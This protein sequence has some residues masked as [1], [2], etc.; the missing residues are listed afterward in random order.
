M[1]DPHRPKDGLR[2]VAETLVIVVVLVLLLKSF[3]AE[4]F[5]IPTGSMATTLWGYQKMVECPECGYRFP[6]NCSDEVERNQSR[7]A[8]CTCPNCR[9]DIDFASLNMEPA[10]KTGDCVLVGKYLYDSGLVAPNRL[11]VVVFKY[12]ERPQSDYVQMNY[13][14][15]LI[16]LPGETIGIHQ[17]KLYVLKPGRGPSYE[18][19][20]SA[21]PPQERWHDVYTH[22]NRASDLLLRRDAAFDIVRKSPEKI[23][24]MRRIVYDNDHQAADLKN[25]LPPRWSGASAWAADGAHAFRHA[26]SLATGV[27]WL[28]YRNI[29]RHGQAPELITDFL[30]YNTRKHGRGDHPDLPRNWV[31]DLL[32]E[33]DVTIDQ[34]QGAL[35]LELSK[36]N[37][38]FRASWD[39]AS[40]GGTCRLTRVAGSK[41]TQLASKRTSLNCRGTSRIRF[42]NV[43]DRLIVWVDGE[44]P[45]GEGVRYAPAERPGPFANDLE[46]AS[47][48]LAG[49]AA[50]RVDHLQLWRD[51]YYTI[52]PGPDPSNADYVAAE[53]PPGLDDRQR[54]RWFDAKR[55]LAS[56][57]AWS[58]PQS[59]EPLHQLPAKTLYVQ[60]NHYLCLGD[61]SPESSD[62]RSWGL[63]P[64]RLLLGR[65]LLVYWPYRRAGPIH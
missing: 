7:I 27:D 3:A 64:A 56:A 10:R 19:E 51:S 5:V 50:A 32:L 14:K 21:V 35:V 15:R 30:G 22:P 2:E 62:G 54:N 65:A 63:V 58:D 46:P 44:L 43:D 4:A 31:G 8:G 52:A 33:C 28:R 17:G 12:P 41:E 61:N 1:R 26:G 45:F 9:L 49:G 36:G 38:R 25:V 59:W 57:E 53:P 34:A 60:P 42:G 40:D 48:G 29:L 20:D 55:R 16:G 13:I 6:V 47:I 23:L 39:L 24:A 37:D 18:A 11:D